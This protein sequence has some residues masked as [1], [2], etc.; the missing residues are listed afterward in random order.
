MRKHR[1][2]TSSFRIN[3]ETTLE[4]SNFTLGRKQNISNV[5]NIV[6][7]NTHPKSFIKV[8]L[9]NANVPKT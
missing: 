5:E 3:C 9:K 1:N 7:L 2:L 4:L 6:S 8:R